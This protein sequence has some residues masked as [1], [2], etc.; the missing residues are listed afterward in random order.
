MFKHK[1]L[2]DFKQTVWN[3]WNSIKKSVNKSAKSH[4][5]KP[6]TQV[7]CFNSHINPLQHPTLPLVFV[8]VSHKTRWWHRDTR[9][10]T[11]AMTQ[12]V[13]FSCSGASSAVTV[14]QNKLSLMA[15]MQVK[16]CFFNY[17]N[18][19]EAHQASL[20]QWSGADRVI[21]AYLKWATVVSGSCQGHSLTPLLS[22]SDS[23]SLL[24]PCLCFTLWWGGYGASFPLFL[25][26]QVVFSFRETERLFEKTSEPPTKRTAGG[27]GLTVGGNWLE[28]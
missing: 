5:I 17:N 6:K 8:W 2:P 18:V 28:N 3:V 26:N 23:F 12:H 14:G 21:N 10:C 24:A 7:F 9:W 25:S 22:D 20:S 1:L 27:L 11:R 19:P 13:S 16:I 4:Q 15:E